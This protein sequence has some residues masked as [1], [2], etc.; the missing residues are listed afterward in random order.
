M[1]RQNET[2][3]T[4]LGLS[5]LPYSVFYLHS[6]S[7]Y[8]WSVGH[9]LTS[10]PN[11]LASIGLKYSIDMGLGCKCFAR[12]RADAPLIKLNVRCFPLG[13]INFSKCT[14]GSFLNLS[15]PLMNILYA[16]WMPKFQTMS[17]ETACCC[18]TENHHHQTTTELRVVS[19]LTRT[20]F[21]SMLISV[22]T[23]NH[24][25]SMFLCTSIF[26]F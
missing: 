8:R 7:L 2:L 21:I 19:I 4:F 14:P 24:S 5:F 6:Q 9:Q 15:A 25:L 22:I 26:L 18:Y 17:I 16:F 13:A 10:Q 3:R 23:Y 12:A 1:L 20:L 11:F